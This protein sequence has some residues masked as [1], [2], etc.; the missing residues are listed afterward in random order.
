ML[1]DW[2]GAAVLGRISAYRRFRRLALVA[3]C[4]GALSAAPAALAGTVTI[5][6][7]ADTFVVGEEGLT[8]TNYGG[9]DFVDTYGGFSR[10]CEPWSAPAYGLLR[11]PLG[12]IP[13]GRQ[14]MDARFHLVE[15]ASYAQNGDP[16]H[17]IVF[18]PNDG[19]GESTV[20]WATR[21]SDGTVAP[22]DPTLAG[23]PGG[24]IRQSVFALGSTFIVPDGLGC[25]ADPIP[26]GNTA[27]AFPGANPVFDQSKN[28]D[29]SERDLLTRLAGERGGDGKLSVEVYN[30][31]CAACPGGNRA[32]W[33]RYWSK[34]AADPAVRPR[35]PPPR[36]SRPAGRCGTRSR[37]RTTRRGP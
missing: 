22:G 9:M 3:A 29:L 11:F 28:Q 19:W 23:F 37:T 33:A 25:D 34:E 17:H 32:Y 36:R 10:F 21:P 12:A 18:I 2:G 16:N 27:H 20:T 35:R 6:P 31:N 5:A 30:P 1:G 13:S 7:E 24:D 26:R 14:L 15:R 8:T 4:V